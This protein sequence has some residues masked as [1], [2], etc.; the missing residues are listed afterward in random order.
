MIQPRVLAP[1]AFLM[2]AG[3]T[4]L[5]GDG[6]REINASCAEGSGCFSGDSPG[7]PVTI[8]EA[9]SY[10]LTSNLPIANV[11]IDGIIVD[12]SDVTL[13]LNGFAIHGPVVCDGTPAVTSCSP[14]GNSSTDGRGITVLSQ[15]SAAIRDGVVR[16]MDLDGISCFNNTTCLIESVRVESNGRDG[17]FVTGSL[18]TGQVKNSF[19]LRNLEDGISGNP[20]LIAQTVVRGNGGN[21]MD[22]ADTVLRASTAFGN[23]ADGIECTNDCLLKG[24]VSSENTLYG[25]EFVAAGSAYGHN[26]FLSNGSGSVN[27]TA[28]QIDTN[29]CHT[30]TC[31]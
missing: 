4:A 22:I 18:G 9:G 1:L 5:A 7:L 28:V 12:A 29:L 30:S 3:S 11:D 15:A 25:V 10:R 6:I 2:L 19:A 23:G 20:R 13:D 31:P 14:T 24:N 8:T 21:G 26:S 27:G 16:G 17:L